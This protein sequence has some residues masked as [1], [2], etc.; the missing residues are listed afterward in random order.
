MSGLP[1]HPAVNHF[2][3]VANLLAA[4]CLALAAARPRRER[5]EWVLRAL[6]LL[7]VAVLSIPVAAWSGRLWSVDMGLW[8][9][10]VP[11]P[12]RQALNGLLVIH[13]LGA[14]TS[15]GLT[16]LGLVL[17]FALR[18]GRIALWPVLLVVASAA[19]ATGATARVG[20]QMA[21]GEPPAA[22]AP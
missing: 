15:A 11:L 10:H 22:D 5:S 19:A 13:V 6:L 2:P 4:S 3:V 8:P 21:Y 17:T 20:G 16:V 14:A 12:P 7:G 18:R 1:L 9:R